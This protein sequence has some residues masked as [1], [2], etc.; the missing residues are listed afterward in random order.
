MISLT[1]EFTESK[2]RHAR[3]WLFYDS[4]CGFCT[5]LARWLAALL[6]KE[7]IAIAPLQ[8]PR[9]AGLLGLSHEELM[10]EMRLVLDDGSTCGG[11]EAMIGI[12]RLIWWAAPLLW[13]AH[14][15][16]AKS[17]LGAGYS[18][19]AARRKCAAAGCS[20]AIA[21]R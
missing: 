13:F 5:R 20:R 15:P 19:V 10:R 14:I 17:L 18:W 2:G 16:G 1:T 6:A 11:A 3:G 4:E 21:V 8:D 7:G 9:V 12:A